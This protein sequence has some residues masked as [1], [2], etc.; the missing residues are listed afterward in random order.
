MGHDMGEEG[1]WVMIWERDGGWV[2]MGEGRGMGHDMGEE[3]D[4]S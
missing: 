4:G 1:E 2:M 3:G